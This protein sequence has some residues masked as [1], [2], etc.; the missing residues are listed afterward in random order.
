MT[1]LKESLG[2]LLGAF[3][4]A[5]LLTGCGKP[6]KIPIYSDLQLEEMKIE[7]V[8]LMPVVDRRVDKSYNINLESSI[9]DKV[10]KKLQKKGY[11]V[12]RPGA[13]S[14][15]LEF[16]NE[17]V[18]E[19]EAREL[20][21][22]GTAETD[23]M[24]LVYLDDASSKTALGYSFKME[25]TGLLLKK[26]TAAMLW[27]DKGIGSQGQGGLAGCMM[28]SMVKGEAINAC[29]TDMLSSFPNAPSKRKA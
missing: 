17:D 11:T 28:S 22:I 29:L 24:L 12:I 1:R 20:G 4:I 9:G 21:A 23:Y 16:T 7:T 26:Q 19:M 3:F 14:D 15:T 18:A 2:A 27:K 25:A 6:P 8:T 5:S 10:A 13:F